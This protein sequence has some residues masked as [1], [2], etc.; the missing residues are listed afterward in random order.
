MTKKWEEIEGAVDTYFQN[1]D[2]H[3]LRSPASPRAP[4]LPTPHIEGRA[5]GVAVRAALESQE[6]DR[7]SSLPESKVGTSPEARDMVI[8]FD[9]LHHAALHS[10]AGEFFEIF[11][12]EII[13]PHSGALMRSLALGRSQRFFPLLTGRAFM[14]Q[15]PGALEPSEYHVLPFSEQTYHPTDLSDPGRVFVQT[16]AKNSP[17][18]RRIAVNLYNVFKGLLPL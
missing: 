16:R 10:E 6:G 3:G 1:L 14:F 13:Q 17:I 9:L 8:F 12:R 7:I 5:I 2:G 4:T 18:G 15:P 11:K